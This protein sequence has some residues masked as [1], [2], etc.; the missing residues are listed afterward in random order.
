MHPEPAFGVSGLEEL[1]PVGQ[2]AMHDQMT[3]LGAAACIDYAGEDVASRALT[4]AGGP[5][6]AIA[7][8]AGG[9][10][11]AAAVPALRPGGQIAAIT[12]RNWTWTRCWMPTSPSTAYSSATT[13][14]AP[15]RSQR[16]LT[17]AR[18]G[19]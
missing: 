13:A 8:L 9:T 1:E 2:Q 18:Y 7:D 17:G 15:A 19:P 4:L 10:L 16:C 14:T 12:T 3:A 11:A 5:L 6:N